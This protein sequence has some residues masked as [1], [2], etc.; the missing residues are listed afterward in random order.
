VPDCANVA[1]A[2]VADEYV[3]YGGRTGGLVVTD[4]EAVAVW[5]VLPG[6]V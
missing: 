5:T 1:V 3:R 4:V 6:Y 2:S